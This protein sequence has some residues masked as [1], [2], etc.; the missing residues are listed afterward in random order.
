MTDPRDVAAAVGV[1]AE[2]VRRIAKDYGL[3]VWQETPLPESSLEI[4]TSCIGRGKYEH[5]RV[6]RLVMRRV[7]GCSMTP[8]NFE[9]VA[10]S[11]GILIRSVKQ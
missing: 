2:T 9:C 10:T 3:G 11:E 5:L 7:F 1:T 4:I 8:R 6:S